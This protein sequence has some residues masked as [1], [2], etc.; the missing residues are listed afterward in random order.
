[1]NTNYT[2]YLSEEE[3]TWI[4]SKPRG[5]T[6]GLIRADMGKAPEVN[7]KIIK[8]DGLHTCKTCGYILPYFKAKCKRCK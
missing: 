2:L 3:Y 7:P 6:R 4:K 8:G 1:M 5:Y